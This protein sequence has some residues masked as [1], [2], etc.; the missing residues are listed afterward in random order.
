[1][2][3]YLRE[4]Y[5][6]SEVLEAHR[7]F[8]QRLNGGDIEAILAFYEDDATLVIEPGTVVTGRDAIRQAL[9]AYAPMKPKFIPQNVDF[10]VTG[11]I[12]LVMGQWHMSVNDEPSSMSGVAVD[13]MRRQGD[14]RWLYVVDNPWG[15]LVLD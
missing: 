13:V 15:T 4:E 12:A 7:E 6:P 8:H 9:L 5:Q 1:M 11:D 10:F 14:G 3:V 2:T